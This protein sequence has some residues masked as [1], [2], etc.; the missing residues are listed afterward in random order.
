MYVET[1]A[2]NEFFKYRVPTGLSALF[3]RREDS[4]SVEGERAVL[5]IEPKGHGIEAYHGEGEQD[6]G[7]RFFVYR[8]AEDASTES[9]ERRV[10][11]E[12]ISMSET[13]WPLSE[14]VWSLAS[15]RD[16]VRGQEYTYGHCA[17]RRPGT[18]P[19]DQEPISCSDD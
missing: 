17:N 6:L 13:I 16:P 8:F 12:L 14:N 15:T 9:N 1:L 3:G 11:Y 5:F 4:V 7:P 19:D 2:H 10:D 18:Q